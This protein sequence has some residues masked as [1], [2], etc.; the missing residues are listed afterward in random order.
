MTTVYQIKIQLVWFKPFVYRTLLVKPSINLEVLHNYI[1]QLFGFENM[2]LYSFYD[3][4][5]DIYIVMNEEEKYE[6]NEKIAKNVKLKDVLP[7]EKDKILYTYDFG[8]N[9][10][11][12]IKLEKI[13]ET[14]EK[15]PKVLR[16]KW[17]YL[18]EDCGWVWG[19][20]ELIEIY[21]KKDKKGA[22]NM[23]YDEFE[24]L[25]EE[26]NNTIFKEIDWK[27]FE[28]SDKLEWWVFQ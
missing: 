25:E 10:E 4:K 13:V 26:L 24:Y 27:D 12:N 19:L 7:T 3:K 14:D 2:H 23:W 16:W 22:E 18:I 28:L 15:L 9:W 6:W 1:Q 17:W 5:N 11:F 8:D 20:E 21:K